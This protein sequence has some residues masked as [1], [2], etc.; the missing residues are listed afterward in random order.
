ML[1]KRNKPFFIAEISSNHNGKFENALKLIRDSKIFGA[2]AV[3]LQTYTPKSM[4]VNSQKKYFLI[5]K[6][7]WRGYN[8]WNLYKKAHTPYSWHKKLFKYGKDI[9]MLIP[10]ISNMAPIK[11][12]N[13]RINDFF[14]SFESSTNNN[15][16]SAFLICVQVK[17]KY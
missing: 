2:N 13:V 12:K 9:G 6:G 14:L 4:T 16:L 11:T 17:F 8:L 7:L 15:L 3:K 5:K 10:I 1:G